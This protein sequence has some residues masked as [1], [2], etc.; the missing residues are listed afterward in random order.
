MWFGTTF[1]IV[2]ACA[3]ALDAMRSPGGIEL[4]HAARMWAFL[5]REQ[6]HRHNRYNAPPSDRLRLAQAV[7]GALAVGSTVLVVLA[8]VVAVS[9]EW[10]PR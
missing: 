9:L 8:F 10:M 6:A 3:F 1:A 5:D 4:F 2:W 7:L